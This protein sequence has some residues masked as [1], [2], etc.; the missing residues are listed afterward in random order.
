[1]KSF[2]RF[3]LYILLLTL[4]LTSWSQESLT[5][6]GKVQ[7]EAGR[8]IEFAN[9]LY[10]EANRNISTNARGQFSF[11]I[12]ATTT[13]VTLKVSFIGKQ[14]IVKEYARKD[15]EDTL[16]ITLREL[17]LNLEDVYVAPERGNSSQSNSAI[18]FDQEAI[19]QTQ[20]FS[21]KDVLNTLP[22]KATEAPVINSPQT[23]TLRGGQGNLHDFN[24]SLGVAIIMDGVTQSN[25]ANMQSRSLSRWGI[26]KSILDSHGNHGSFDTPFQGLDLREIPVESIESIEVIQGVASAKYGELTDGAIIIERQAGRTP[27][28][29]STNINGGSTSASLSKGFS[30]GEKGGALNANLNYTNSNT[31]PRDKVNQYNRLAQSIMWTK[32]FGKYIKNTFS[33]DY[34]KRLDDVKQ[35]PDDAKQQKSYSS[36]SGVRISSRMNATIGKQFLKTANLTTSYNESWQRTYRQMVLN[37]P[38]K[39]YANKDT[40]GIYEGI[41]TPGNFVAKEEIIGNPVSFTANLN[42]SGNLNTGNLEHRLGYGL[43]YSFTNNGGKGIVSDPERP[44]WANNGNQ[45]E[46]PYSFE[47]NPAVHNMG[48]YIEDNIKTQ[49]LGKPLFMGI[50]L[51]H[52]L[53]NGKGYL[54]PRINTRYS[55]TEKWQ[56]NAAFGISTKAPTLAHRYPSPAWIDIPLLQYYTGYADQSIYLVFTDKI[57]PDNSLLK[58]S[59]SKQFEGGVNYKNDFITSSIFAY[60]KNNRD[61]FSSEVDY[62]EYSLPEYDYTHQ[63]GETA[64]YF[65]TGNLIN[66]AGIGNYVVGNNITSDTYG[67]EWM[68][69]TQKIKA[70]ETS[71]NGSLNFSY[72]EYFNKANRIYTLENEVEI[73]GRKVWYSVF[74]P[75]KDETYTLMTKFSSST[76]I[77][78]IGFII[79][80]NA[81]VFWMND[82]YRDKTS[83]DPIAYINDQSIYTTIQNFDPTDP[84]LG[85]LKRNTSSQKNT[86]QPLVYGIV[87]LSISKEIQKNIR[88]SITAYNAFNLHPESYKVLEDGSIQQFTYNKPV[89]LTGGINIKF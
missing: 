81:D 64:E 44:R 23:I 11:Q 24:N 61:G 13:K 53:Q 25:D 32:N 84:V 41:Y 67:I 68:F 7:D 37:G 66:Y 59:Q 76:H 33:V 8:A 48:Y 88:F 70:I 73:D 29:F 89:S 36:N 69:S 56:L 62:R 80:F 85:L 49:F 22:G 46:R 15:F 21:L 72:S 19:Q 5:I 55:I 27:Y 43:H 50:G 75:Q 3:L 54:Q 63:V 82:T 35:D 58:A 71:F 74:K 39:G 4:P 86:I 65:P 31:D 9:I 79:R 20:A 87:N 17:S 30:L 34:N 1:M 47:Y 28:L 6:Q 16:I 26:S 45:N 38:P 52:D 10:I 78:K 12:D 77:P 2:I 51:R 18:I 83:D 40:T 57:V 60:V 14:R 42:F